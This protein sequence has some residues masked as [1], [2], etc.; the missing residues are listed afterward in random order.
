MMF[1]KGNVGSA[2]MMIRALKAFSVAS[3]LYANKE[4]SV[5]YFGSVNDEIQQRILQISGFVKGGYPFR[6]LSIPIL[7]RKLTSADC[8]VMVEKIVKKILCCSSRH[9]SYAARHVLVNAVMLSIHTY[10]AQIFIMPKKV[11]DK[12]N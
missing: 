12:I 6:Y 9:L 10:W 5:V 1:C 4:K 7:A 11:L 2:M 3:S 8:D